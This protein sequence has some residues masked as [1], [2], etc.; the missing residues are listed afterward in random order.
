M[1]A[2]SFFVTVCFFSICLYF[3]AFPAY[4]YLKW[5]LEAVPD[6]NFNMLVFL[7]FLVSLFLLFLFKLKV[8]ADWFIR[9][10]ALFVLAGFFL[11][12]TSSI[13]IYDRAGAFVF[14]KSYYLYIVLLFYLPVSFYAFNFYLQG[15]YNKYTLLFVFCFFVGFM[16]LSVLYGL[17]VNF[18][19]R[20]NVMHIYQIHGNPQMYL[21]ISN[22][23]VVAGL[24]ITS[25]VKI[26]YRYLVFLIFFLFLFWCL[27]RSS[28]FLFLI[29]FM[30]LEIYSKRYFMFSLL[31]ALPLLAYFIIPD[32]F[33]NIAYRYTILLFNKEEDLSY[34]SRAVLFDSGLES[35]YDNILFG[36]YG[37][38]IIRDGDTGG[39]IHN[40]ISYF[41]AYGLFYTVFLFLIFFVSLYR[42]LVYR[43]FLI[44]GIGLFCLGYF[45][46]AFLSVLLTK[47][48]NWPDIYF[49]IVFLNAYIYFCEKRLERN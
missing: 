2:K 13:Q 18:I 35:I 5:G 26:S 1:K 31:S 42:V 44:Q 43:E 46:Y 37:Y 38:E 33:H 27:S 45:I 22:A 32:F 10:F 16:A 41:A 23:V 19:Y 21:L 8:K 28:L 39:Y 14:F 36:Y 24:F 7:C 4:S 3:F 17:Y 25:L 40:I 30:F 49:S 20:G 48:Y 6:L 9:F 47:S 12:L 11:S 34:L 15:F 29:T